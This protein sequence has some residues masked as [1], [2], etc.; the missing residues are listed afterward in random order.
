MTTNSSG[1]SHSNVIESIAQLRD[2]IRLKVHLAGLDAKE[3]WQ[4]L[5]EQVQNLEHR[6]SADGGSLMDAT[7]TL[8]RDLKQSLEHFRERLAH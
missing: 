7:A 4:A 6:V 3:K 1:N 8:A 2:E 5:E